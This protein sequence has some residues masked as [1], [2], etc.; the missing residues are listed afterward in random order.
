MAKWIRKPPIRITLE[1]YRVM[2]SRT[3]VKPQDQR[4]PRTPA[5]IVDLSLVRGQLQQESE[6]T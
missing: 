3:K 2:R 4:A 6:Q 1:Q 5:Q